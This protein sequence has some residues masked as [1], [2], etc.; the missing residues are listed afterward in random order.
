MGEQVVKEL[1]IGGTGQISYT[2]FLA[3]VINLRGKKPEEQ[4]KLLWIAWEQ[5]RPDASGR[6]KASSIQDALA[7]RRMTV[8][9]LPEGFLAALNKASTGY[10]T[11]DKFK[12]VLLTDG[13]GEVVRTLTGEKCRG[14]K[15]MRWLMKRLQ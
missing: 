12:E 3:G 13:S 4:D 6:V 10:L 1:D 14:A 7:T 5:F 15:L 8:A 9:D 2:E 11:F